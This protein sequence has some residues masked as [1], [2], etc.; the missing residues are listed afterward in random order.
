MLEA[1]KREVHAARRVEVAKAMQAA[2]PGSVA[3]F[4]A[5]PVFHRNSD[6]EHEYRQ[7]SDVHFL[8]GFA[9]PECVLVIVASENGPKTTLFVRPR[10]PEREIWDGVRAGV[11]GAKAHFG[12]D[13][14]FPISELGVEL[15]KLLEDRD[16]LYYRAGRDRA[17]DDRMFAALDRARA[18]AKLG[19]GFPTE[20]VDPATV[21]HELRLHKD[22]EALASMRRAAAIT[23]VA[24]KAC[25]AA[26]RPGM[27]E[28]EIEAI[29]LDTFRKNGSERAA[30]GSIVGSGPNATVLHYRSNDRLMAEGELLLIDAGCEYGYHASDVTR[31][32][33]VS[34]KFTEPQRKIYDLVL[35]AQL[36]GFAATKPG[37]T[38]DAVHAACVEVLAKGLL[39]LG[40]LKGTLAEVLE[41]TS[42]KRFYM[43]KTSHW[44]GMDV[45]DVGR[46]H[47]AR[48]ARPLA[49]G[50]VLTVEPGLYVSAHD[51]TVAP[52]WR[53]IGVRIED[54]LLVT[55]SGYENLTAE[56]PKTVAEVE[57]ACAR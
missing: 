34:G 46:Y 10:D 30:Y 50:M 29:L 39:E 14:A 8:S 1:R 22:A 31:T 53:G 48:K 20:I 16:R 25:M 18:R 44:L 49:P 21:V 32:F 40:L 55:E 2:S 38:L 33:P 56:I 24:H 17:F 42:Y 15:P 51:E 11:D 35:A 47:T 43:H 41:T 26:V 7:D 52:E 27:Y 12:A 57:A 6:V 3:V 19:H 54:D 13:E 4:P 5:T 9:E 37:S 36:A 45:H 23:T 28:Y